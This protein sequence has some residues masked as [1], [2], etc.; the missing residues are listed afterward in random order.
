M[1]SL[2][3]KT[4]TPSGPAAD[5]KYLPS[6]HPSNPYS[7]TPQLLTA[8]KLEPRVTETHI[9]FFGYEG[10]DPHICLQQW[11]PAPFTAP[12]DPY[13]GTEQGKQE[14][15][16]PTTEHYMMYHK[17]LLMGDREVAGK[18]LAT[19][20]AHPSRAK[21]LG[22]EVRNF[23]GEVWKG[24]ADRVV[25]EANLRKFEQNEELKGVLLGT[26]DRHLVEASPDD[27]IWGIGFDSE[28]AEGKES[29]WGDNRLG[30][31]LMSVRERL[32]KAASGR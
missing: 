16:F 22:R 32:R 19:E 13:D 20:N 31:A 7:F 23:D 28:H 25:E 9:Y 26:G 11:F 6:T 18:M 29:E 12:K 30:E 17:A 1:S 21:A 27:R 4:P 15:E 14:V 10:T 5:P 8:S 2:A 3:T 24:E